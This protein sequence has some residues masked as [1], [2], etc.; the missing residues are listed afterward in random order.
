MNLAS[1]QA[2]LLHEAGRR[3]D[4]QPDA[5]AERE[6]DGAS[7][8]PSGLCAQRAQRLALYRSEL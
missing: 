7:V 1:Y 5:K 6:L 8:S 3:R 4:P 2:A